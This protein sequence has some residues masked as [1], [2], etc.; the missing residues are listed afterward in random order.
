MLRPC[1]YVRLYTLAS[2]FYFGQNGN[3]GGAGGTVDERSKDEERYRQLQQQADRISMLIVAGDYP[4]VDV[5]I[6]AGRLRDYVEE[7]FPDRLG[8][9]EVIYVSR[10]R[11]LWEQFRSE[12]EPL[13]L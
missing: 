12:D 7:H 1:S 6:A 9:F 2:R 3:K 10:F 4:A 8:L 13:P 5:A 11:R